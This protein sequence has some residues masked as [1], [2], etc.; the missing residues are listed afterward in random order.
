MFYR[1]SGRQP[2]RQE[3]LARLSGSP[4]ERI[5]AALT[6]RMD[7]AQVEPIAATV[8]RPEIALSYCD[9]SPEISFEK[10]S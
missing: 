1:C 2:D 5:R 3:R 4:T 10:A 9:G 6:D 8:S 7:T